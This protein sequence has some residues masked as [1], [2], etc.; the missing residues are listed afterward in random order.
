MIDCEG[1]LDPLPIPIQMQMHF[2]FFGLVPWF[3]TYTV[4]AFMRHVSYQASI[5]KQLSYTVSILFCM[6]SN[7]CLELANKIPIVITQLQMLVNRRF[8]TNMN[9]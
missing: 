9:F 5:K 4:Q 3:I 2:F 6:D 1:K 7:Q 8:P